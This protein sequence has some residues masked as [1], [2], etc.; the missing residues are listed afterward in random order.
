MS[1]ALL[2]AWISAALLLQVGIAVAVAFWRRRRIE[3]GAAP[4]ALP[5]AGAWEGWREFRV[6]RRVH[7]DAAQTLCSFHLEPVDG[8]PLPPFVLRTDEPPARQGRPPATVD[9]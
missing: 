5:A 1:A 4:P 2:L 8:A 7:E 9:H 3:I 6:V